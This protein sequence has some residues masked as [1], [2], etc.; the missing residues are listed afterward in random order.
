MHRIERDWCGD[1]RTIVDKPG[2]KEADKGRKNLREG[3]MAIAPVFAEMP[4]F[5]NEEFTLVDCCLAPLL[6]RLEVLGVKIPG[7]RQTK[8]MLGY[9]QKLFE[10]P[11]FRASL[12]ELEREMR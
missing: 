11:S 3:F 10:R 12:S 5:M 6:W 8:P 4:F 2:S 9:M 1:V 7:S